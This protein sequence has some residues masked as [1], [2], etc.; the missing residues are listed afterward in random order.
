MRAK[1]EFLVAMFGAW[2]LWHVASSDYGGWR[3]LALIRPAGGRQGRRR[4]RSRR[5][6]LGW[7]GQR[8]ANGN[9]VEELANKHPE[10]LADL[11]AWLETAG[12]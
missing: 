4:A 8:L 5:Y 6:R 12:Q 2:E 1:V 9:D 10:I 3:N 11:R 7:N